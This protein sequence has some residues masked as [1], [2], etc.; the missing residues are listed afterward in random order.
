[1]FIPW[2]NGNFTF[3]GNRTDCRALCRPRCGSLTSLNEGT[4]LS[5]IEAMAS[6]RPVISTGVGGVIDLL[7]DV[8]FDREAF[9]E[10]ERGIRVDSGRVEDYLAELS[11]GRFGG[12]SRKARACRPGIRSGKIWKRSPRP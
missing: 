3:A 12:N 2:N 1:M 7:G 8:R 10:C 11:P 5:L 4:P 9:M 6:C